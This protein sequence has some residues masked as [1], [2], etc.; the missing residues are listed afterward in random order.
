[1]TDV[2]ITHALAEVLRT[3]DPDTRITHAMAEVLRAGDPD[4]RITHAMVEVLRSN[5]TQTIKLDK[6]T[7]FCTMQDITARNKAA[8]ATSGNFFLVM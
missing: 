7:A 1:M 3:G 6:I 8:N 5:D 2:R 4:I